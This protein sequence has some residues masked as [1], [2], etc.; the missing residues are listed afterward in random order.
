MKI[1]NGVDIIEICRIKSCIEKYGEKFLNRIYTKNE[2]IYCESKKINRFE[3]YAARFAA[4][5]A[6]YK[7][8]NTRMKTECDWK[9][10]E[11]I[12]SESGKPEVKLYIEVEGLEE[13]EIS[14][15]H[16]KEQSIA[17]CIAVFKEK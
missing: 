15:S 4:K 7:A 5:E 8:I 9:D 10:I 6:V 3:S 13:I 11:I 14:L 1:L 16:S 2:I 17:S 12:N